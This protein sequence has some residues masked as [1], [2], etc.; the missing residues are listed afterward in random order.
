MPFSDAVAL[1]CGS[2]RAVPYGMPAGLAQVI[3]GVAW[4]TLIC[5]VVVAFVKSTVSDGVNVTLNVSPVPTLST[6]FAAGL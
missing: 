2:L 1:S 4:L 3:V 5:T 6:A